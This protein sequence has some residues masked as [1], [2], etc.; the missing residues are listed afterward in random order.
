MNWDRPEGTTPSWYHQLLEECSPR[1]HQEP[2]W[3]ARHQLGVI[4]NIARQ[5]KFTLMPSQ[6]LV[7]RLATEEGEP[8]IPRWAELTYII[9]RQGGKTLA[10]L[11]MVLRQ[12]I[13]RLGSYTL[14]TAQTGAAARQKIEHDW[15]PL[16]E[17]TLLH[18]GTGLRYRKG[19]QADWRMENGSLLR[20]PPMTQHGMR[21]ITS[22]SLAV[23]DEGLADQDDSR[24]LLL[25]P[26]MVTIPYAQF[27][28]CSTAGIATSNWLRQKRKWG[29]DNISDLSVR[30][31]FVEWSQPESVDHEDPKVWKAAHPAVGY[32]ISLATMAN[33]CSRMDEDSFRREFLGIWTEDALEPGI[34]KG[35]WDAILLTGPRPY[36][37]PLT[38]AI[39]AS[40]DHQRLVAVV[41]DG[42]TV[43]V[44][45]TRD[46]TGD[47][48]EWVS[49]ILKGNTD[50]RRLV[51]VA[52]WSGD[53][54]RDGS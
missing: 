36:V 37:G 23:A 26:T 41:S 2:D 27:L 3:T 13:E 52:G 10:V 39:D 29:Q 30:R 43:E 12:M 42:I 7:L 44:V 45:D 15:W 54:G 21:G 40:P 32:T 5:M 50:I 33:L 35:A 22:I 34:S 24:E 53:F 47:A 48:T 14:Y 46:G 9:P 1:W 4:E 38:M 17:G 8:G 11:L 25:L 16:V 49:R 18:S 20:A 19:G 6:K 28:V 51:G 31:A